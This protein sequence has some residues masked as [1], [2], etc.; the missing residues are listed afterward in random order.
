[1]LD[2]VLALSLKFVVLDKNGMSVWK[3]LLKILIL[4]GCNI[5]GQQLHKLYHIFDVHWRFFFA[6]WSIPVITKRNVSGK[7]YLMRNETKN[8]LIHNQ[9]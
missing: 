7:N 1:M 8:V 4:V 3:R 5:F 6:L 2:A 9:A